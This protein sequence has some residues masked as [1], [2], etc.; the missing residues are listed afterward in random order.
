MHAEAD[1]VG[2]DAG[3][4]EGDRMDALLC[5]TMLKFWS[6]R[7]RDHGDVVLGAVETME[8]FQPEGGFETLKSCLIEEAAR[9]IRQ[10]TTQG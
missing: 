8:R 5:E 3:K 7:V 1:P 2:E 9:R 6:E 10:R 4:R